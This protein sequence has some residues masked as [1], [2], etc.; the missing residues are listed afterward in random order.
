M[1]YL[2]E[3]KDKLLQSNKSLEKKKENILNKF[4]DIDVNNV[5]NQINDGIISYFRNMLN[6]LSLNENELF[7][8]E[9]MFQYY[10][11]IK[12]FEIDI[13]NL[14][15][16]DKNIKE[17]KETVLFLCQTINDYK[18][19]ICSNIDIEINRN[20][21]II[22]TILKIKELI[23]DQDID[24]D[25]IYDLINSLP[26]NNEEKEKIYKEIYLKQ[27]DNYKKNN[28]L[29]EEL[30][31]EEEIAEQARDL[32][33]IEEKIEEQ[34]IRFEITEEDRELQINIELLCDNL[35]KLKKKMQSIEITSTEEND[36]Y[37]SDKIKINEVIEESQ[38]I[39]EEMITYL[40]DKD[41]VWNEEEFSEEEVNSEFASIYK[42]L[43]EQYKEYNQIYLELYNKYTL[44]TDNLI[45][46]DES[47]EQ[48]EKDYPI[49]FWMGNNRI[50]GPTNYKKIDDA[51]KELDNYHE[52][53]FYGK[54]FLPA[55]KSLKSSSSSVKPEGLNTK[56]ITQRVDIP[57]WEVRL[58]PGS[59]GTTRIYYNY[60]KSILGKEYKVVYL[61]VKKKEDYDKESYDIIQ[62][63]LKGKA[64]SKLPE[65]LDD[66]EVIKKFK[67]LEDFV[68]EKI[69]KRKEKEEAKQI[70]KANIQEEQKQARKESKKAAKAAKVN[71]I[72]EAREALIGSMQEEVVDNV[73]PTI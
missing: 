15:Y 21:I 44:R 58:H 64:Y 4:V 68:F 42:H 11:I 53:N 65:L 26:I 57:F 27:L 29:I 14:F 34:G 46:E 62:G 23:N 48:E 49:I 38:K 30:S 39:K 56:P 52:A 7:R 5:L 9:K 35:R 33:E 43:I 54:T 40:R 28:I 31:I 36:E 25:N 2:E 3:L 17:F 20:N 6:E 19:N 8:V 16:E 59:G 67:V 66:E 61:I 18:N 71:A 24:L 63:Y 12:S 10:D 70:E 50:I 45:I 51:L 55:L 60:V 69:E 47:I 1:N 41:E 22:T 73:K 37:V 13:N 72:N 32:E